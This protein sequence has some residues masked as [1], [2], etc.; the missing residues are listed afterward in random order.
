[1]ANEIPHGQRPLD[2]DLE[3]EL[4]KTFSCFSTFPL[5]ETSYDV[6]VPVFGDR[7]TFSAKSYAD[8]DIEGL[9]WLNKSDDAQETTE[10]GVSVRGENT[11]FGLPLTQYGDTLSIPS[12][13]Q[14]LKFAG[15]SLEFQNRV[16]QDVIGRT[17][18]GEKIR[19]TDIGCSVFPG[20]RLSE[21][22]YFYYVMRFILGKVRAEKEGRHVSP[23]GI[24]GRITI[25]E[26][27]K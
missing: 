27:Q 4:A 21:N 13:L 2:A 22:H 7:P 15:Y 6:T 26:G 24:V 3:T 8:G 9:L 17:K 10:V 20:E 1:M 18:D 14:T 12:E 23:E 25:A 5:G 19:V 16:P 11:A